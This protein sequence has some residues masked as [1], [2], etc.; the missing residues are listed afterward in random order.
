GFVVGT[1]RNVILEFRRKES[2]TAPL[3]ERDVAED[4]QE[5]PV[6]HTVRK[7]MQQVF[8][9]LKPRE[10]ELLRLYYY[11]ELS[12]EEI[13]TQLGIDP[14]RVRLVKSRALKSFR[15]FYERLKTIGKA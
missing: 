3:G 6:D 11:E 9:K 4:H 14:E 2:R 12:K 15:E 13:G 10:R 1:A 8:A 5:S 7:A